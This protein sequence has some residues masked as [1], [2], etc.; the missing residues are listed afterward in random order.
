[1]LVSKE[2][3]DA[4][5]WLRAEELEPWRLIN[6]ARGAPTATKLPPI[7]SIWY[8]RF[9]NLKA[10][11]DT[12]RIPYSRPNP[13][14]CIAYHRN[15][16]G[17]VVGDERFHDKPNKNRFSH[18]CE[19]AQYMMLGAGEGYTV[20]TPPRRRQRYADKPVR[21]SLWAA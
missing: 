7:N 3:F 4:D 2:T 9:T 6:F 5:E 16:L 13:Y 17:L 15:V 18:P 20:V 19:A 1:M 14:K 11:M 10:E 12:E 8:V 21:Y